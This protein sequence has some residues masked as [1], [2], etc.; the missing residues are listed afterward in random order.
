MQ[1]IRIYTE[2]PLRESLVGMG[3]LALQEL[4]IDSQRSPTMT[5]LRAMIDTLKVAQS[6]NLGGI[7]ERTN[8]TNKPHD[9]NTHHN[10]GAVARYVIGML[11]LG[12]LIAANTGAPGGEKLARIIPTEEV[13]HMASVAMANVEMTVDALGGIP[14]QTVAGDP[15]TPA[16]Q[17]DFEPKDAYDT[18]AMSSMLN[19]CRHWRKIIGVDHPLTAKL[20][21]AW[22]EIRKEFSDQVPR[23]VEMQRRPV[24]GTADGRETYDIAEARPGYTWVHDGSKGDNQVRE[25]T[26]ATA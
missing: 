13:F 19:A 22:A 23:Y 25:L 5:M 14:G 10:D 1:P 2:G 18:L 20:I 12:Q 21:N 11:D 16:K 4:A 9:V 6:L 24:Y 26:E 8:S 3:K 17:R 7:P 15:T